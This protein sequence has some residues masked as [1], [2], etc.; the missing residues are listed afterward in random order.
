[1][2]G[3]GLMPGSIQ[4]LPPSVTLRDHF[5]GL[6]MQALLADFLAHRSPADVKCPYPLIAAEAL[7][8][9]DA[10]IKERSK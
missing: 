5:S 6:A 8:I 9:A 10:M 2:I 4:D 1:M 7:Y 3:P